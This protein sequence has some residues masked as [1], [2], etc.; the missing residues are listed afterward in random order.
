MCSS[1]PKSWY[2]M[3]LIKI[4]RFYL[5]GTTFYPA[6]LHTCIPRFIASIY[7]TFKLWNLVFQKQIFKMG[8][9]NLNFDRVPKNLFLFQKLITDFGN[10]HLNFKWNDSWQLYKNLYLC[11]STCSLNDDCFSKPVPFP[12]NENLHFNY[13]CH[14]RC[15]YLGNPRDRVLPSL[16][17][18]E[19]QFC[20][21]IFSS[22]TSIV[23]FFLKEVFHRFRIISNIVLTDAIS[24]KEFMKQEAPILFS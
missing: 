24:A 13:L 11:H 16:P 3:F 5:E 15:R 14:R 23:V 4:C 19:E 22:T 20:S 21:T 18:D 2:N 9:Q 7:S 8:K 12:R 1:E 17:S 10:V 6:L